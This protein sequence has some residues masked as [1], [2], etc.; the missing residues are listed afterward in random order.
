M[1]QRLALRYVEEV[2]LLKGI[3][4]LIVAYLAGKLNERGGIPKQVSDG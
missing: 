2:G 1:R 3:D 4:E